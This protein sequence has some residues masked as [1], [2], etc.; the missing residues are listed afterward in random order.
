M[1]AAFNEQSSEAQVFCR[2]K[3]SDDGRKL[4][5]LQYQL[6]GNELL[7]QDDKDVRIPL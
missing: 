3:P 6:D 2:L 1:E 7:L 5:G 4:I